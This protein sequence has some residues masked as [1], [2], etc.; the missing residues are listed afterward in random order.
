[1]KYICI[2]F[3]L[4]N[5]NHM[6]RRNFRKSQKKIPE[7]YAKKLEEITNYF[8]NKVFAPKKW[9]DV[10]KDLRDQISHSGESRIQIKKT[11]KVIGVELNWQTVRGQYFDRLC[12]NIDT[13]LFEMLREITPI[14]FDL[15]WK[16]GQYTHVNWE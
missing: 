5:I 4:K 7:K 13:G 8:N 12:Q 15:E 6:T 11:E 2:I 3:E 14:L 16:A 9:G 10:L 1:M